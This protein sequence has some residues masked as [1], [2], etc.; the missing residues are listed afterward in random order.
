M[1]ITQ[2]TKHLTQNQRAN[3]HLNFEITSFY[4]YFFEK[5]YI[6]APD[7]TDIGN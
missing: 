7:L 1:Q 4:S 3:I 6:F 5:N 2:E